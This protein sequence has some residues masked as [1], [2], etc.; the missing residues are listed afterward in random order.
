MSLSCLTCS[1]VL[2][3]TDSYGQDFYVEKDYRGACHRPERSWSGNIAPTP[4]REGTRGGAVAKLKADHRRVLSTGNVNFSA[5]S[6]PRLVRSSG[7]RRDWSFENLDETQDQRAFTL[8]DYKI[9]RMKDRIYGR[10]SLKAISC[11]HIIKKNI[12]P[13]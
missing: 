1:Q 8:M 6:E 3:R 10:L 13:S 2:Q 11:S 5:N 4:K 7:M 9:L 12:H